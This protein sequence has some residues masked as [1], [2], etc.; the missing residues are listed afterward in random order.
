MRITSIL[1]LICLLIANSSAAILKLTNATFFS[2]IKSNSVL[3]VKFTVEWCLY[4]D[5]FDLIFK[6]ADL[7]TKIKSLPYVIAE[8]DPEAEPF[9]V[10]Y[11][12]VT[13]YPSARLFIN[14]TMYSYNWERRT[15]FL[16]EFIK[17]KIYPIMKDSETNNDLI[18]NGTGLRVIFLSMPVT[19]EK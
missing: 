10:A 6:Q 1:L 17:R 13:E 3:M 15:D 12:N 7:R 4:C 14:G 5:L 19:Q 2:S 16:L 11:C 18:I 9:I 8:V